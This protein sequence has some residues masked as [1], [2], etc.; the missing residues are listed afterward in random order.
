MKRFITSMLYVTCLSLC[1]TGASFAK[2]KTCKVKIHHTRVS[3]S[4]NAIV[5]GAN[6]GSV[7]EPRADGFVNAAQIYPFSET[8]IYKVYAA[9]DRVTD[10]ALQVGEQLVAIST[11]DTARWVIGDTYSGTAGLKQV[12]VLVKPFAAGLKTNLVITTSAR[13]Y[14]LLAESTAGTAMS[15]LSWNYP[16][17]ELIA[18]KGEPA[19]AEAPAPL[20]LGIAPETLRFSYSVTGDKPN[21]RPSHVFDDG[22]KVY[23][24]FPKDIGKSQMPPLFAIGTDGKAELLNYRVSY[25]Y[26]IVDRLVEVAELRSGTNPQTVVRISRIDGP[27]LTSKSRPAMGGGHD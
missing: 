13:T 15:S 20:A 24:E 4:A 8:A 2:A 10:I 23:I 12:H 18:I 3:T 6:A 5:Q 21:W 22:Q 17:G 26:F 1:V 9:P 27:S 7:Q 14:H 16:Q 11:G 25:N 19:R